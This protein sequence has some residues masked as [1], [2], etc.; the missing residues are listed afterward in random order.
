MITFQGWGMGRKGLWTLFLPQMLGGVCVWVGGC[1]PV[2]SRPPPAHMRCAPQPAPPPRP[3]ISALPVLS[4]WRPRGRVAPSQL[5][6]SPALRAGLRKAGPAFIHPFFG[7]AHSLSTMAVFLLCSRRGMRQGTRPGV[8]LL[9]GE[10]LRPRQT[11][12]W[13]LSG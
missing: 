5:P 11:R 3:P 4:S 7:P 6:Q 10:R 13:L 8:R 12:K 1:V 2:C 9:S